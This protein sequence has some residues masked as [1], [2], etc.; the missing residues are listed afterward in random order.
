MRV[1]LVLIGGFHGD[2][3]T[4]AAKIVKDQ[5]EKIVQLHGWLRTWLNVP[6]PGY[7]PDGTRIPMMQH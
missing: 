2:L 6:R 5:G 1:V 4:L 3:Y 7:N